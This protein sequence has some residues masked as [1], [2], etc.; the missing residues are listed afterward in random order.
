MR[1]A[2]VYLSYLG[3][4]PG[5]VDGQMGRFTRSAMND[6]QTRAQLPLTDEVDATTFAALKQQASPPLT[7]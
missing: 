3:Y 4:D 7:A 5:P 6:F 2:Q 1:A